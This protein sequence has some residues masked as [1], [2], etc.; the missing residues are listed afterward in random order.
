L[1]EGVIGHTI[2]GMM[3][4]KSAKQLLFVFFTLLLSAPYSAMAEDWDGK[5][6]EMYRLHGAGKKEEALAHAKGL[7]KEAERFPKQD[8]RRVE[9]IHH[10]GWLYYDLKRYAEAKPYLKD[11]LELFREREAQGLTGG[12]GVANE[13][14]LLGEVSFGL[15]DYVTALE[16]FEEAEENLRS[17]SPNSIE[18]IAAVKWGAVAAKAMG[19]KDLVERKLKELSSLGI[20]DWIP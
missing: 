13:L 4:H 17:S 5:L 19:R 20:D 6:S 3:I 1:Q 12:H 2:F 7:L 14:E 9:Q 16:Y 8:L 11:S 18:H 15:K 10:V